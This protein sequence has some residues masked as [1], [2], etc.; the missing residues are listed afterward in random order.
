MRLVC[1]G[2]VLFLC[3]IGCCGERCS[4]DDRGD[5]VSLLVVYGCSVGVEPVDDGVFAIDLVD[6]IRDAV[7]VGYRAGANG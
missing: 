6:R 5:G 2:V 7:D 1:R 4:G 3:G